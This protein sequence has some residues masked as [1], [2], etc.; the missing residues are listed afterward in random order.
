MVFGIGYGDDMAK[1]E[2]IIEEVI[3]SHDKVLAEPAP[4]VKVNELAD[5]SV[6]FIVR[7]WSKTSDYWDVYWDIT[8]AIKERFDAE[9]VGIPFP[10][11]TSTCPRRSASSSSN[12]PKGAGRGQRLI[13]QALT[14]ERPPRR[15]P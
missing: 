4:V 5:N 1:A 11:A 8:R 6:N 14:H 13:P 10:S 15:C 12:E 3:A 7:P 9:G 2:S